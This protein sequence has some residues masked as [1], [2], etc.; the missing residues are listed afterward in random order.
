MGVLPFLEKSFSQLWAAGR[1][2]H[3]RVHCKLM[4]FTNQSYDKNK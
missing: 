4:L 1:Q 2:L 3:G